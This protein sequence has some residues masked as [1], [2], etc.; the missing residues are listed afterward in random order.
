[1]FF[2]FR[3]LFC[4]LMK[5]TISSEAVFYHSKAIHYTF[6]PIEKKARESDDIPCN[7][8]FCHI[9]LLWFLQALQKTLLLKNKNWLNSII[10]SC[11]C[12]ISSFVYTRIFYTVPIV[13]MEQNTPNYFF[14]ISP[15]IEIASIS[16]E[17]FQKSLF[18]HFLKKNFT[19]FCTNS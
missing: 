17:L 15:N 6:F 13:L 12:T 19:H 4:N 2:F 11:S 7:F 16:E 18:C 8:I 3:T 1:M 5:S 10:I 14:I 9:R